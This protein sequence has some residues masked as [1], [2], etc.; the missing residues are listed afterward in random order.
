[1]KILEILSSAIVNDSLS[2]AEV[3][4]KEY[5]SPLLNAL[6][7]CYIFEENDGIKEIIL[8]RIREYEPNFM[9]EV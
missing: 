4:L 7:S 5:I 2:E 3:A 8:E 6:K 9:T 1:M